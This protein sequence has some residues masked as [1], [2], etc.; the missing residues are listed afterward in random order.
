MV[1]CWCNP[2]ISCMLILL[3]YK[4]LTMIYNQRKLHKLYRYITFLNRIIKRKKRHKGTIIYTSELPSCIKLCDKVKC[5]HVLYNK[6]KLKIHGHYIKR[7]I[8]NRSNKDVLQNN[9]NYK[10]SS[11]KQCLYIKTLFV[12]TIDKVFNKEINRIM[13]Y[14]P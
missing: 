9:N 5:I 1:N 8:Y 10:K 6:K 3:Y 2:G 13:A 11:C 7:V 14:I 12:I 4:R